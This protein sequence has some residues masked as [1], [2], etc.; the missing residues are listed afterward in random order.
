MGAAAGV[1]AAIASAVA[2]GKIRR[3]ARITVGEQPGFQ[4]RHLFSGNILKKPPN[5]IAANVGWSSETV[6]AAH[7]K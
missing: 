7:P 1:G 2:T 3:V 4:V 5:F 6:L